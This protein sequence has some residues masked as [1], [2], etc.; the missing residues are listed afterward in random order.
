MVSSVSCVDSSTSTPENLPA[1]R[2]SEHRL[3][4]LHP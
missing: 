2:V 1:L 4:F 3:L